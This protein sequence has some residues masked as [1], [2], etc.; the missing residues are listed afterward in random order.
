MDLLVDL[1][2]QFQQEL[3]TFDEERNALR[4]IRQASWDSQGVPRRVLDP[5][6]RDSAPCPKRAKNAFASWSRAEQLEQL[7]KDHGASSRWQTLESWLEQH[8]AGD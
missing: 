5:V 3:T 6:D 4:D 8:A 7:I 2:E 1:E